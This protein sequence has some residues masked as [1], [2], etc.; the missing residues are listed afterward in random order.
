VKVLDHG[1]VELVSHT[2]HVGITVDAARCSLGSTSDHMGT[3]DRKLVRYLLEHGHT[4]PFRHYFFTFHVKAP[5]FVFRQWWKYQVGSTW[6]E[7]DIEGEP[8]GYGILTSHDIQMDSDCG[9]SWNELS[10]RYRKLEPE[11]Y[12]PAEARRN[13]GRQRSASAMELTNIMQDQLQLGYLDATRRYELMLE[14]GVAKELAR[15]VLPPAI[16]SEAF[17]TVSL[18][19]ILHFLE[20]RLKPDAQMEIRHYAESVLTLCK[21][22]LDAMGILP[23]S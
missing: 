11:F 8:A 19:A 2:G 3:A 18:Q 20:Q 13:T 10:G 1:F 15:L 23:K 7:Y 21:P 12:L 17:W 22:Q 5:L 14:S 16:Y 9:S 4:S 6:R